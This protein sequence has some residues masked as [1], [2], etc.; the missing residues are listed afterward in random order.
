V[1]TAGKIFAHRLQKRATHARVGGSIPCGTPRVPAPRH[2]AFRRDETSTASALGGISRAK[3]RQAAST[4]VATAPPAPSQ[5]ARNQACI[6]ARACAYAERASA[7]CR[8]SSCDYHRDFL[9][10]KR[11]MF[12]SASTLR[13]TFLAGGAATSMRTRRG[14]SA[15]V[16]GVRSVTARNW[17]LPFAANV[18]EP[19]AYCRTSLLRDRMGVPYQRTRTLLRLLRGQRI[20]RGKSLRGDITCCAYSATRTDR[21]V[22]GTSRFFRIFYRATQRRRGKSSRRGCRAAGITKNTLR[23]ASW[24][25]AVS[26]RWHQHRG[27]WR[28]VGTAAAR[29]RRLPLPGAQVMGMACVT[30]HH[31]W[32]RRYGRSDVIGDSFVLLLSVLAIF[33]VNGGNIVDEDGLR[34]CSN[35]IVCMALVAR[36]R[37]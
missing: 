2:K 19:P 16:C 23:I 35:A 25:A 11:L 26:R 24:N 29:S 32:Q 20:V 34:R 8:A 4:G 31:R 36:A 30:G 18:G 12:Y 14:C 3:R 27:A 10:R 17:H 33:A 7:R 13:K 9:K 22:M 6:F 1:K 21:V 15:C 5:N 28:G 37:K